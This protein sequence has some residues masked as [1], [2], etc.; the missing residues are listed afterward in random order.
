MI[1]TATTTQTGT[2]WRTATF[3]TPVAVTAG[4]TY[5]ASYHAPVGRWSTTSV[6][7]SGAY[8]SGPL[9]V[10]ANGGVTGTGDVRPTT[11]SSTNYWVDVVVSI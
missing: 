10:P 4:T 8:T 9:T 3:A 7:Y 5:T 6:S 11:A 2:G 1:G